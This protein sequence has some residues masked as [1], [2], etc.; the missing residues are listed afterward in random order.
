MSTS[1]KSVNSIKSDDDL[2]IYC[3]EANLKVKLNML[4]EKKKR[5]YALKISLIE[6]WVIH[7]P[8]E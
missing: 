6:L 8:G 7:Y 3:D 1:S 2:K 4:M 5:N